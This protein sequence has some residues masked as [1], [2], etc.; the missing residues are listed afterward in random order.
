[1]PLHSVPSIPAPA[2]RKTAPAK[3]ARPTDLLEC[4]RCAGHEVTPT[5]I[6]ATLVKGKLKGGTTQFICTGCMLKGE[7]VVLG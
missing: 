6:G 5:V 2:K 3:V 1:M 4:P 7:R